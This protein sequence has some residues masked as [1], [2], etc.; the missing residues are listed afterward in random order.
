MKHTI[1]LEVPPELREAA[2]VAANFRAIMTEQTRG[3]MQLVLDHVKSQNNKESDQ[4]AL[5][6]VDEGNRFGWEMVTSFDKWWTLEDDMPPHVIEAKPGGVLAFVANG[7]TVF[8]SRVNHPGHV[9]NHAVEN[10][11]HVYERS[12]GEAISGGLYAFVLSM[13]AAVQSGGLGVFA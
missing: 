4:W 1:E 8:A 9:G 3:P 10:A 13:G 11:M 5:A 7:Q 2:D 12:I 6:P